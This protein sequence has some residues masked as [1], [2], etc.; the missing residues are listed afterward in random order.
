MEQNNQ[1]NEATD[2]GSTSRNTESDVEFQD[3]GWSAIKYHHE[4]SASKIIQ[5][6][7]KYSGGL[8]KNKT[9]ANYVILG[10]VVL[11]FIISLFS[12]LGGTNKE[13]K[14]PTQDIINIPQP[15][16]GYIPI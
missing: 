1:N 13:I 5:L 12:L 14:S 8:I 9:Q 15:T 2:L 10:F 11:V 16:E 6:T 7:M 4:Q 3:S